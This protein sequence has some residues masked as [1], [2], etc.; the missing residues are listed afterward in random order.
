MST[1]MR[2][3]MSVATLMCAAVILL[4]ATA[5]GRGTTTVQP[6]GVGGNW[7]LTFDDEFSGTTLDT[8]RWVALQGWSQNNVTTEASNVSV[9]GGYLVL[10]LSSSSAGAEVSSSPAD[11]AGKNGYLLPVGGFLEARIDFPGSGATV[12]NW[13]AFWASGPDWPYDGEE[14]VAEGLGTMTSNYHYEAAGG[15]GSVNSGTIPGTWAGGFHTYGIYRGTSSCTVYYDGRKVVSYSTDDTGAGQRI[16]ITV[17]SGWGPAVYGTR[18]Q[19]KVD[20][21]RAWVPS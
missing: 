14:D 2:M 16:L 20:Y 10:T 15:E 18:S 6:V 3:G 5:S 13:P 19:V 11:G 21:V 17:G 9:A 1:R 4:A 7:R 8:T 12:D